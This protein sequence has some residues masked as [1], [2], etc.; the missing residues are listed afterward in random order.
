MAVCGPSSSGKSTC[1]SILIEALK[2]MFSRKNTSC[3][4]KHDHVNIL[5]TS[6]LNF[7]FGFTN[8]F[9]DWVDGVVPN[10]LKKAGQNFSRHTCSTWITL[11]GPLHDYWCYKLK[12]LIGQEKVHSVLL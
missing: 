5:A 10:L 7:M 6:D 2:K 12:A 1:V 9:G 4:Y 8:D 11:D 3:S